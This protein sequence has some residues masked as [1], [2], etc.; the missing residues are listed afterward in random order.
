MFIQIGHC[1]TLALTL[2]A[3][4]CNDADKPTTTQYPVP[5][6]CDRSNFLPIW[7]IEDDPAANR[8]DRT[9]VDRD[10]GIEKMLVIPVYGNYLHEGEIDKAAIAH[11]FLCH[12]GDEIEKRLRSFGQR[13]KLVELIVWARGYFPDGIG[14]NFIY[15]RALNGKMVIVK[16]LQRCVGS[17]EAKINAAMKELL[18]GDFVVGE[19]PKWPPIQ[20]TNDVITVDFHYDAA[21][22]VRSVGYAGRFFRYGIQQHY[23]LLWGYDVGTKIVNRFTAEEKKMVADF[24]T[25]DNSGKKAKAEG[26]LLDGTY[27]GDGWSLIFEHGKCYCTKPGTNDKER[28]ETKYVVKDDKVYIAPIVPKGKTM[29]RNAWPVYTIKGDS[30]ESSH[31]EDMDTGEVFYKDKA[32][33][34]VLKKQ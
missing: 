31:V 22:V 30:L 10:R 14:G 5:Q 29:T 20:K 12:P 16:E 13:D 8:D 15:I 34:V 1:A 27:T 26:K 4:G 24:A 32:G 17:E 9:D 6:Y 21:Q 25:G 11:P 7:I 3:L 28:A 2:I 18:Q 23:H 33:K 19:D